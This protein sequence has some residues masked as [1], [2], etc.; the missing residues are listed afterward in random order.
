MK[1]IF[2]DYNLK[3]FLKKNKKIGEDLLLIKKVG[4]DLMMF[5]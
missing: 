1:L 3:L 5:I 2:V 4:E